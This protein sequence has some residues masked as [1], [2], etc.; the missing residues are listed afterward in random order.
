MKNTYMV[1]LMVGLMC[2][3]VFVNGDQSKYLQLKDPMKL[4]CISKG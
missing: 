4:D 1:Q 3:K 2:L